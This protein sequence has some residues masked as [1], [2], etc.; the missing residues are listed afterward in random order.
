[1]AGT[2]IANTINTD[3]GVFTNLNALNG[4]AKAW[5]CYNAATATILNSFNVSSV[6]N[7]GAG[8]FTVNFTTAMPSSNYAYSVTC[9]QTGYA[10][11]VSQTASAFRVNTAAY[12]DSLANFTLNGVVVFA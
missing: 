6:T 11:G 9:A 2:I 1:M 7:N 10:M 5:L 4:A 3:T 12:T 8:D